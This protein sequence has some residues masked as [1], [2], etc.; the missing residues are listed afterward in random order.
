MGNFSKF[1]ILVK[2]GTYY[3]GFRRPFNPLKWKILSNFYTQ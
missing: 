1:L 2:I 3:C